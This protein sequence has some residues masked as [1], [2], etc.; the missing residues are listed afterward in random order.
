MPI[1]ITI[2]GILVLVLLIS[3]FRMHAFLAFL[4]VTAGIG[5][6]LGMKPEA[7]MKSVQVGI[8]GTLGSIAGIIA[9]G[10]M[11]GKLIGLSGAA[12]Q[13]ATKMTEWFG[14]KHIRWAFMV[15]GFLVG[16]PLF[17]SVGFMLLVP[18][19]I[20]VAFRNNLPAVYVGLPLLASL[21]VTQGYLPPHPAPLFLVKQLHA[22]MGLTMLY[23][24]IISVPAILISGALYGS[25]VKKYTSIPNLSFVAPPVAAD[26]LPPVF[27]SILTILLPI[28]L[29]GGSSL[30]APFL[31]DDSFLKN[32][33]LFIGDANISLLITILF[34]LYSLQIFKN[35]T[36]QQVNQHLVD[37]VKDVASLLLIF[38]GA[39]A[40]KQI[41][42]DGGVS[43][44]IAEQLQHSNLNIYVLGWSIA[45]IIRVCVGSSTV[46]GIT[47]AGFIA[48]LMLTARVNPN[49]MVLSIGAGSMMFSHVNDT[50]FWLFREYFQLSIKDTI[51]TWSVMDTLVSVTGLLGVLAL[52]WF[53]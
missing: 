53:V 49:L 1:F 20:T 33:L 22:D 52:E 40:L 47:T 29:I 43:Q 10:A 32:S 11:L 39:G 28:L 8:G 15:T 48:P 36:K 3:Y 26:K 7:L 12:Q 51:K 18:I 27:M 5:L 30:L 2:I 24:I 21:S 17:Y 46:A 44:I 41:L 38:G 37:A 35:N 14:I 50:G 19:A 42:T 45:A 31:K 13:I 6:V 9:L 16:L 23:G 34:A 4:I 25:T